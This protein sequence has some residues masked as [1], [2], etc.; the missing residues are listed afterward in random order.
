MS[1]R[2]KRKRSPYGVVKRRRVQTS[3]VNTAVVPTCAEASAPSVDLRA[4]CPSTGEPD[5]YYETTWPPVTVSLDEPE[6]ACKRSPAASRFH[7]N[8]VTTEDSDVKVWTDISARLRQS[9]VPV[10]KVVH[11]NDQITCALGSWPTE[12][13]L[14]VNQ[15]VGVYPCTVQE[16]D[17]WL[18]AK[19][20]VLQKQKDD[21]SLIDLACTFLSES[22]LHKI[23]NTGEKHELALLMRTITSQFAR[24]TCL[25]PIVRLLNENNSMVSFQALHEPYCA[26]QCFFRHNRVAM[27]DSRMLSVI[28]RHAINYAIA[29][30][31]VNTRLT[32]GGTGGR[33]ECIRCGPL[34]WS[35]ESIVARLE[36]YREAG[37]CTINLVDNTVSYQP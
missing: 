9:I 2:R 12:L 29:D 17:A 15:Y 10:T 35:C 23:T 11:M 31:I 21:Y 1:G 32:T 20:E 16:I 8:G 28:K 37:Y 5:E 26:T 3:C 33:D 25:E 4:Q 14:L 13:C 24:Y 34:S 27:M 18:H 36:V 19:L 30:V 7:L 6:D 22:V